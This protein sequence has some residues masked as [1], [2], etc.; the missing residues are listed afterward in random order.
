MIPGHGPQSPAG[1]RTA[2]AVVSSGDNNRKVW[3]ILGF[4]AI[5]LIVAGLVGIARVFLNRPSS[6]PAPVAQDDRT[7]A[8]QIQTR[9]QT[10]HQFPRR[11]QRLSRRLPEKLCHLLKLQRL[12]L[13]LRH[14]LKLQ[15]LLS[16]LQ[17]RRQFQHQRQ[18]PRLP[19][20]HQQKNLLTKSCHQIDRPHPA[21]NNREPIIRR[22]PPSLDLPLVRR[23][24]RFYP[25]WENRLTLKP[26]AIGRI[27]AP[28]FMK[29]CPIG[30]LS[31]TFTIAIR[32]S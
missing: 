19:N 23:K 10:P 6:E 11:H 1:S 28:H 24:V 20:P 16:K 29:Y 22:L 14:L 26:G 25:N 7:S 5:A 31:A 3:W 8:P 4:V 27:L 9:A 18:L 13:K 2:P 30:L 32:A 12:L 17:H 15:R 21:P